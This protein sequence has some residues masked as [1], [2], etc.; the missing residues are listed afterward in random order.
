MSES[1]YRRRLHRHRPS[2]DASAH[3]QNT[4]EADDEQEDISADGGSLK[5]R[6]LLSGSHVYTQSLPTSQYL[7]RMQ[8]DVVPSLAM[9]TPRARTKLSGFANVPT[10]RRPGFKPRT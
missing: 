3:D 6:L 2:F 5:C 1:S 10:F 7:L 4:L 9:V 8:S